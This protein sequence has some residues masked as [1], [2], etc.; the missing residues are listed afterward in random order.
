MRVGT[1]RFN[2]RWIDPDAVLR[3][4][5]F[6]TASSALLLIAFGF[7]V[8]WFASQAWND[9]QG[10]LA[11]PDIVFGRGNGV[12]GGVAAVSGA[13]SSSS[14]SPWLGGR[15]VGVA[16]RW[17]ERERERGLVDDATGITN[18]GLENSSSLY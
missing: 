3:G 11:S 5:V 1:L 6:L 9:S 2:R 13:W 4:Q 10:E 17:W 18:R 14:S 12:G 8:G 7:F 16:D 15:V